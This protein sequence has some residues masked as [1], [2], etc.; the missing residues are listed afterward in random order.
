MCVC[1]CATTS[2]CSTEI[3]AQW[4]AQGLRTEKEGWCFFNCNGWHTRWHT[5]W[6]N[7]WHNG[8]HKR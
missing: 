6:H 3:G 7:G 1:V 8:W 2:F 5:G 4:E